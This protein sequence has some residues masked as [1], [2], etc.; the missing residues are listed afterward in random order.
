MSKTKPNRRTKSPAKPRGRVPLTASSA[1]KHVLYEASVQCVDADLDFFTR[2]FKRHRGRPLRKLREDFCGTA[3]LACEFLKRHPENH[4]WGIDLHEPTLNWGIRHH[5]LPLGKAAE[6]LILIRDDVRTART[7][8]MDA[9][10]AL[11]FSYQ[12]FKSRDELR[13]YFRAARA[14]LA[15]DGIFFLDAFGGTEAVDELQETRK[16]EP[17]TGP[18]GRIYDSFTYV[19]DQK[20]FNVV[21]NDILC[22]IHFRFRDGTEMKRAFTYDWRLWS[23]PELQEIMIEAGFKSTEVYLEGWDEDADDADGVFR[24]R[25]W[26]DN[27]EGWVGYVVGLR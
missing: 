3:H 7:P 27:I 5:V 13:E 12:V 20:E 6:R 26:Y 25:D 16:I 2:V 24:R 21:R 11:N 4:A 9:V 23:L 14:A 15:P 1:N 17:F 10:A 22:H 19:W 18:D 8:G